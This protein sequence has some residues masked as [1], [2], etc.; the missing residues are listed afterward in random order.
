M[1]HISKKALAG[2]M[3]GMLALSIMF[4]LA[5]S[6]LTA[7][8][9]PSAQ[10]TTPTTPTTPGTQP[11]TPPTSTV[12]SDLAA[13]FKKNFAAALGVDE[14]KL[15]SSYT[16][17][18]NSTVDAAV[19]AGTLTQAQADKIKAAAANGFQGH[20][21]GGKGRGGDMGGRG[22]A[23]DRSVATEAAAKA[24]SMT[25]DELKAEMQAG[26]SIATVA[27]AKNVQVQ[28]VKDAMLAAIKTNLDQKVAAGT[29]TQAQ[30]DTAYQA[31]QTHVDRLINSARPVR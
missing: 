17:A 29:L 5:F 10:T 31:A 25:L 15:N 18:V 30:A 1:K 11:S 19:A 3:M 9:A 16:S 21:G 23:I 8:A 2:L 6:S 20:L 13:A 14:A 4:G 7:S 28:T 22:G 24:L 26:K 12:K 27:A